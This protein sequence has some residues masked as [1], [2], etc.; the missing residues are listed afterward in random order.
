M[1]SI[2]PHDKMR[3]LVF[4]EG[5]I[6]MHK[7]ALGHSREQIVK[8]VIEG[9]DPSLSDW[10]S[11]ISIGNAA[12]KLNAWKSEGAQ[13]LYLTSRTTI[14]DVKTINDVL[15]KYNFPEG[16]LLHRQNNEEYKDVAKKAMPEIIIEDDCES[17]GG[18]NQMTF[19]HLKLEL[20]KKIKLIA[21][22]EFGGIDHLPSKITN[23]GK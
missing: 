14:A 19:F 15:T 11:Y 21:I 7:G 17:I 9:N 16:Q 20:K 8:Q 6:I 22:K 4:T 13:I 18:E 23:L 2:P 12:Q 1:K 5:T 10:K 3:I